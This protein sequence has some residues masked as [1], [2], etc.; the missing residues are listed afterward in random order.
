MI[1]FCSVQIRSDFSDLNFPSARNALGNPRARAS[2]SAFD[3]NQLEIHS[4]HAR[5]RSEI[6]DAR[7]RGSEIRLNSRPDSL[8]TF[9]AL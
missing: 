7:A 4:V 8:P 1:G 3:W 2:C 5:A 6:S 9:L